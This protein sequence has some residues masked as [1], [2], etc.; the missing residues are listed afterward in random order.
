MT[1]MYKTGDAWLTSSNLIVP[2]Q[3]AAEAIG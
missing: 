2:F 1:L 3:T